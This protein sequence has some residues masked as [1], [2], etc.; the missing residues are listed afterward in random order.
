MPTAL[1]VLGQSNPAASTD[2]DLYTVPASTSTVVSS[3]IVCNTGSTTATVRVFVAV[4]G[5]AVATKQYVAYDLSVAP[6]ETVEFTNGITLAATDKLRVRASTANVAFQ[7]FG[8]E[9]T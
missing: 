3:I 7:A 5:A 9:V 4:G 6:Y 2:T 8:Q 1:K